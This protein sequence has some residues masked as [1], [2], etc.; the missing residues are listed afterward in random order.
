M[1]STHSY[2]NNCSVLFLGFRISQGCVYFQVRT[3]VSFKCISWIQFWFVLLPPTYEVWR[4]WYFH[5]CLSFCWS[6][7]WV[8]L[9]PCPLEGRRWYLWSQVPFKRVGIPGTRSFLGVGMPDP[10]CL[11][12]VVM[13]R[14]WVCQSWG[15][16]VQGVGKYLQGREWVCLGEV[17]CLVEGV[18]SGEG[19]SIHPHSIPLDM[20]SEGTHPLTDT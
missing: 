12:G 19:L 5:R 2:I 13:S 11:L 14:E 4:R 18:C 1:K 9:V 15:G 20:G 7:G 17:V 10:R 8:T 16:Y 6:E 3:F